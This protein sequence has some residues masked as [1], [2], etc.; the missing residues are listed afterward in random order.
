MSII[1]TSTGL[2]AI[3][4]IKRSILKKKIL[5]SFIIDNYSKY[6]K[7]FRYFHMFIAITTPTLG[8]IS[9]IVEA[10][11]ND[12]ST[13]TLILSS[14]VAIMIKL[15]D[16]LKFDKIKESSKQQTIKY[17]QLYQRIEREILK[18]L[19]D[20]QTEEQF[21][22]WIN[23]EYNNIEMADPDISHSIKEKYIQFCQDNKIPYDNDLDMLQSL[24]SASV[25]IVI[26]KINDITDEK[27]NSDQKR[28]DN[29]LTD[30]LNEDKIKM[31]KM[32]NMGSAKE[33]DNTVEEKDNT[34]K[35]KDNTVEEKDNTVKEKDNIIEEKDNTV[36]EKD[37]IIEEKDNT[38]E[39]KDNTKTVDMYTVKLN[40]IKEHNK[41]N[42][43]ENIKFYNRS[44]SPSDER[45]K[46]D[47]KQKIQTLD[48]RKDLEWAIDRLNSLEDV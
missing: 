3:N 12:A 31:N 36:K 42:L 29:I 21:L 4:R 13:V 5:L 32:F 40:S 10:T 23:R 45:D 28:E 16:Y 24:I 44:R 17:E 2:S 48:T 46:Q 7:L 26:D 41:H 39:E 38:V 34:V 15:K 25:D 1:W 14:I 8:V 22:Y 20:R 47:Y 33:K 27:I 18:P 43:N 11:N 30:T 6:D 9:R 19:N 37:N 35:E